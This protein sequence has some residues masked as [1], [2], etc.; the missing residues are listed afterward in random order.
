VTL[1]DITNGD[2]FQGYQIFGSIGR[3]YDGIVTELYALVLGPG[4]VTISGSLRVFWFHADRPGQDDFRLWNAGITN[5]TMYLLLS[6]VN[7]SV[8]C[9]ASQDSPG[10]PEQTDH[11]RQIV[12][13]ILVI[14]FGIFLLITAFKKFR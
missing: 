2:F 11:T 12:G 5:E 7:A 9:M 8:V 14:G 13:N 3:R 10:I 1:L 4:N 6:T